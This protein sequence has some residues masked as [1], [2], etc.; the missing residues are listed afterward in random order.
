[1]Q[2][3]ALQGAS[4]L[5]RLP[6]ELLLEILHCL[7]HA[8]LGL[9][10]TMCRAIHSLIESNYASLWGGRLV[11]VQCHSEAPSGRTCHSAVEYR[12][13]MYTIG[14]MPD[15]KTISSV[16]KEL[17]ILDMSTWTWRTVLD[18][19]PAVTEQTTVLFRESIYLFG[20]YYEQEGRKSHLYCISGLEDPVPS[21]AMLCADDPNKP[22]PRSSHT[23]VVHGT[24]MYVFGG[25]DKVI[26][27]NDL[28]QLDLIDYQWRCVH[29][30]CPEGAGVDVPSAR[31]A[32]CAFVIGDS[33][34]VFGG[35]TRMLNEDV[36]CPTD[37][38]NALHIPTETWLTHDVRGE[39][40]CP[41][42]RCDGLVHGDLFFLAGGWD[43]SQHLS[44]FHYFSAT[45][46]MWRKLAVNLPFGI[47]QHS[48]I[49]WQEKLLMFGGYKHPSERRGSEKGQRL[50]Q[51]SSSKTSQT[52]GSSEPAKGYTAND[53]HL[54][55]LRVAAQ[56][57][58]GYTQRAVT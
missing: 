1:M 45:T 46:C 31:R 50:L 16:K 35:T 22:P 6:D 5:L 27:K 58:A 34:Y 56:P 54:Y 29:S 41:R 15:S 51:R 26:P 12:D 32:H 40:P 36:E 24:S 33:M 2:C 19:V 47:V 10:G 30:D 48:V 4:T 42:S 17:C 23:A 53:V 57:P 13:K 3:H 44:D 14:G 28:Y 55:Q 18:C 9:S 7:P 21:V 43:R 11:T 49:K 39:V 8:D 25:W 38:M 37:T 52:S 20:G